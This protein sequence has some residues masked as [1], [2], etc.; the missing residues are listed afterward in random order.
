MFLGLV[1]SL[2]LVDNFLVGLEEGPE[3]L[4]LLFFLLD[5]VLLELLVDSDLLKLL[6]ELV[7]LSVLLY[8]FNV[9]LF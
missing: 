8:E 6:P 5:H 9:E 1:L 3:L 7:H 4:N 2:V